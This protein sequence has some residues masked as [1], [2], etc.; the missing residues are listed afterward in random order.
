MT[1]RA[2]GVGASAA[3]FLAAL[4]STASAHHAMGGRTPDDLFTGL[5]SG[6]A[7]PVIGLDHLAFVVAV[8]LLSM[9]CPQRFLMPLAFVAATALGTLAHLGGLTLP[10][11][12]PVIAATVLLAGGLIVLGRGLPWPAFAALFAMAG[13]FHGYAYGESIFGAEATPVLSY[14][15]GFCAIQYAIAVAAMEGTRRLARLPSGDMAFVRIAGG[16][17]AGVAM[18]FLHQQGLSYLLP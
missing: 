12:E 4:P 1:L 2:L 3:G 5:I 9:R 17:I 7:H 13:L 6:L 14:L 16:A 10:I 11:A 18:V 8:G 15:V